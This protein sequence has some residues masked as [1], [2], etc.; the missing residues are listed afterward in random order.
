MSF[1]KNFLPKSQN[2]QT[3]LSISA[4]STSD[5]STEDNNMSMSGSKD[6]TKI[7][8]P[9]TLENK[10]R[11]D[12]ILQVPANRKYLLENLI[13]RR[14]LKKNIVEVRLIPKIF[15]FLNQY[16]QQILILLFKEQDYDNLTL[17]LPLTIKYS[18]NVTINCFTIL[19]K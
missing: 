16:L 11:F 12:E 15:D 8:L 9:L 5:D 4:L 14:K 10:V 3:E 7:A 18:T 13:K 2:Q 17:F 6:L 19:K 1:A